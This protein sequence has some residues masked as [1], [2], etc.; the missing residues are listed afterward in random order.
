MRTTHL[1]YLSIAVLAHLVCAQ[2]IVFEDNF[3]ITDTDD[4]AVVENPSLASGRGFGV[5]QDKFR[6]NFSGAGTT[7]ENMEAVEIDDNKLKYS[8]TADTKLRLKDDSGDE[9]DLSPLVGAH[10]EI[11]YTTNGTFNTPLAFSLSDTPQNGDYRPDIEAIY[12]FGLRSW[13]DEWVVGEDGNALYN[14]NDVSDEFDADRA[15]E[16]AVRVVIDERV[17]DVLTVGT[18]EA[19]ALVYIDNDLL[20]TFG[21]DF[22]NDERFIQ[23]TSRKNSANTF[24]NL[25]ILSYSIPEMSNT[26]LIFSFFAISFFLIRRSRY[27][28]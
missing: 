7:G 1:F 14:G 21:I 23:I 16:Y 8:N 11:S 2:T 15:V 27:N 19:N 17:D 24:D 25:R 3:N 12:D 6:Y 28:L 9:L 18:T 13:T 20:G 4:E 5:K 10:Y 26:V 22:E